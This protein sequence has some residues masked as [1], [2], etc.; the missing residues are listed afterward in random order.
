MKKNYIIYDL[1]A[2]CE[3]YKPYEHETIEIGAVKIDEAGNVVDTFNSFIR[4]IINTDLSDYCKD[5]THIS[6]EDVDTADAFDIVSKEF[7][8]WMGN[9][10]H[11]CS[12]GY[13]D[14]EQFDRDC[15]LHGISND[16]V[17][18]HIS[19][20]HQY[21]EIR[22]VKKLAGLKKALRIEG[23]KFEGTPHRG[24]DDAINTSKVFLNYFGRWKF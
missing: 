12:W 15:L 23:L 7:V 10:Y 20:K 18:N 16:W 17:K 9:D 1:E 11:L 8:A 2:T 24:I 22:N 14:K 6:Q 3:N 13:F 4:P 5:L 19:L 21:S